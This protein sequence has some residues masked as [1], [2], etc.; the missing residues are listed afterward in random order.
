MK[1]VIFTTFNQMVE[2]KFGL[3]V[4]DQMLDKVDPDSGRAYTSGATYEDTEL[5]GLAGALSEI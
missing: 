1:G 2:E 5:F 3:E 4:W